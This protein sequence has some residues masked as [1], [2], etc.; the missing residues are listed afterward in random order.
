MA[1][2][3]NSTGQGTA[4]FTFLLKDKAMSEAIE[5]MT[6][7][8][9]MRQASCGECSRHEGSGPADLPA[10]WKEQQEEKP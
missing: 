6:E 2:E 10:K 9:E 3:T 4:D 5:V 7:R 8:I 1:E